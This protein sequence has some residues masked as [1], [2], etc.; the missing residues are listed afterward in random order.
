M[1]ILLLLSE[2]THSQRIVDRLVFERY[3]VLQ[4]ENKEQAHR[5]LNDNEVQVV[6]IDSE[7]ADL[8]FITSLRRPGENSYVYVFYLA[9]DHRDYPSDE[10]TE[11]NADEFLMKPIE[12]DE[13]VARLVVVSRYSQTLTDIRANQKFSE[14][15]RDP[16]TGAFSKSTIQELI[17]T[18]I[19][20]C[21]RFEKPFVL[22]LL[23]L[24]D[25]EDLKITHGQE[26]LDKAM[27][28]VGLKIWATVRAYDLIGRWSENSFMVLLPETFLS[29]ATVVAQRLNNRIGSVPMSLPGGELI[30]LS[31]S[32]SCVQSGEKDDQSREELIAVIEEMYQ[33]SDV[34]AR[35]KIIFSQDV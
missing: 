22:A 18:E 19:S 32:V 23:V 7:K 2:G 17:S 28:Q 33:K 6:V 31:T 8:D 10:D 35:N 11:N 24:D 12:P 4:A 3:D 15:I 13:L 29:G 1:K 21:K 14:P 9:S 5:L 16:I 20:R 34:G 27:A 25:S 30:E 26:T